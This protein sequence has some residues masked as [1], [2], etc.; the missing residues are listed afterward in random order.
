MTE[1][2]TSEED[3]AF[4]EMERQAQQRKEAVKAQ[5]NNPYRDQVIEEIALAMEAAGRQLGATPMAT[6]PAERYWASQAE[7]VRGFKKLNSPVPHNIDAYAAGWNAALEMAAHKIEYNFI[8]AFGKDTLQSI[9]I[10][11]RGM[12]R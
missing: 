11:I 10:Y 2:T 4:N 9:A 3:E 5:V 6:A 8:T 7:Y 1:Y 12:K